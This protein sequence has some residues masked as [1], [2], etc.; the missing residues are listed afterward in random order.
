QGAL[1]GADRPQPRVHLSA[2]QRRLRVR[3]LGIVLGAALA[4][5][6]PRAAGPLYARAEAARALVRGD[7]LALYRATLE[8]DRR[9]GAGVDRRLRVR[10]Q[11]VDAL[12]SFYV[13]EANEII[14][15][16]G[17]PPD[18]EPS[19]LHALAASL[20]YDART[21]LGAGATRLERATLVNTIVL[22]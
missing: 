2:P 12:A 7:T 16:E 5:C 10:T 9:A 20:F 4:A 15:A 3:G 14:L 22:L 18:Q 13:D 21:P 17:S 8:V 19:Q 1:P 6:T 11:G